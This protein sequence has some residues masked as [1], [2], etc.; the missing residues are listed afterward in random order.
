MAQLKPVFRELKKERTFYTKSGTNVQKALRLSSIVLFDAEREYISN[1]TNPNLGA[2]SGLIKANK[3]I[4]RKG[5]N[6]YKSIS[7]KGGSFADPRRH[8]HENI[9]T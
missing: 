6:S 3:R 2:F 8:K 5:T 9:K 7:V 1:S 4:H